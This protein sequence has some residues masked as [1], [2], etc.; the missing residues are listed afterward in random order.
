VQAR[1]QVTRGKLVEAATR[2]LVDRGFSGTSTAQVAA[3]AE[4]SQGALFKHFAVKSQ[5]LGAC[6]ERILA[7]M[8]ADFRDDAGRMVGRT[9]EERVG[10]AVV[11][12]WKIFRREEMRAVFEVYVAA[13]TDRALAA[14][15]APIMERHRASIQAEARRLFPELPTDA[16]FDAAVDAVVYA[17]QGV[18]LGLFAPDDTAE[19]QHLAF[20]NRL[21]RHELERAIAEHR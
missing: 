5:L 14:E 11:A 4:V 17:M 13:R 9:L 18:V 1:A 20:F 21:A 7:G 19:A 10:P 2:C 15:L 6:V 3:A 8:V 16:G 12:L